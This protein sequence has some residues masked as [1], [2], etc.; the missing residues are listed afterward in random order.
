MLLLLLLLLLLL[1]V[2]LPLVLVFL[3]HRHLKRLLCAR[4]STYMLVGLIMKEA[5]SVR[6]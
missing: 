6:R 2:A 4:A 1:Q 3:W 5:D